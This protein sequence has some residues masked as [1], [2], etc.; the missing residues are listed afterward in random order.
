MNPD[1]SFRT[2]EGVYFS[3]RAAIVRASMICK[4]EFLLG[5]HLIAALVLSAQCQCPAM[6]KFNTQKL[7]VDETA[8]LRGKV[9][10]ETNRPVAR[11]KV[12]LTDKVTSEVITLSTGG[13]GQFSI[14]TR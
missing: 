11:V 10:G 5:V 12:H 7:P 8:D 6:P 13:D 4:S 2:A 9:T 1:S 14:S 3:S